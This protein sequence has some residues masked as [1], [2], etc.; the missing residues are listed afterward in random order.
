MKR[1]D[2]IFALL[3]RWRFVLAAAVVLLLSVVLLLLFPREEHVALSTVFALLFWLALIAGFVFTVLA[4]RTRGNPKRKIHRR[5]DMLSVS[6]R[7][8]NAERRI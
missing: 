1:S 4:V 8:L 2:A 7:S 6:Q 3:K 5:K